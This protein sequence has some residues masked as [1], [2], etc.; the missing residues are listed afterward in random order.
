MKTGVETIFRRVC[1]LDVHRDS[2]MAC[3]RVV[4]ADG[5]VGATVKRF[6]TM[7]RDLEI[8]LEWLKASAVTHVAMESTGVFWQPVYNLLEEHFTVWLVN[9]RHIK[10]VPGR[11]TDVKDAE[12]IAQLLQCGLLRPSLVPE[13]AQ[14][15]LR[16][17]TRHRTRLVEQRNAVANRIQKVL[18]GA[19]IKLSSVASDILGASG[20]AMLEAI[21]A[22]EEDPLALAD[23]AQRRMRAKIPQLERALQ[24][25][26]T[27]HQRFMLRELLEQVD[28]LE[29][30]IEAV[31]GRIERI[32]PPPFV[33]ATRQL[34][35]VPGVGTR[36]AQAVL[37][38]IGTEA[39]QFPSAKHLASWA[40]QCPGNHES[41]GKHSSGRTRRANRW[42]DGAL[43]QLAHAAA[44][45]KGSYFHAQYHHLAPRRGKKRAIGAVKHSLLVTF[46]SMLR[47]G[48]PYRDL[49]PNHFHT[50]NTEQQIRYHLRRLERLGQ[51]VQITP[52]NE[53]A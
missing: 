29:G 14:R 32:A 46:Y 43:T 36:G 33:E 52:A 3:V 21:V 11:K 19:N 28:F 37:A 2:V 16:E 6:G 23:L 12:W 47:D 45:T 44:R 5:R 26:V 1:G 13:R 38:E 22:G 27:E 48:R 4:E 9:A 49:G 15:E 25:K 24:G 53:A 51:T 34:D 30:R 17:L 40:G 20:R 39:S 18:Q 35:A 42:L 31:S 8:L 41:A 7:T 10:Q 50:I